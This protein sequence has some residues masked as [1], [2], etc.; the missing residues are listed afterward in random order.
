MGEASRS[1]ESDLSARLGYCILRLVNIFR[2][3]VE[4]MDGDPGQAD[5]LS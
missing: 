5:V 4:F 2:T 1:E 3:G